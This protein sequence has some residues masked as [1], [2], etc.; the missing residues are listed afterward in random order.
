MFGVGVRRSENA[1]LLG[2]PNYTY[3]IKSQFFKV[4]YDKVVITK[5]SIGK[6]GH[7]APNMSDQSHI[8]HIYCHL[9]ILFS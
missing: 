2:G 4:A 9:T 3:Y 6:I 1:T 5:W 7:I 8:L